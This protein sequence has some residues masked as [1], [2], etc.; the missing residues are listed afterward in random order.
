GS[1]NRFALSE[2]FAQQ[3]AFKVEN[4]SRRRTVF[5][6]FSDCFPIR[7][8]DLS[9]YA[10]TPSDRKREF[11]ICLCLSGGICWRG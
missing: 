3:N 7:V 5:S 1:W 2:S 4:R 6:I 9:A 11:C 8:C 10:N